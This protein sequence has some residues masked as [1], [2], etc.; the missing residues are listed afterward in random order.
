LAGGTSVADRTDR[1]TYVFDDD[2][3]FAVRVALATYRPL[4]VFGPPGVGKSSLARD[5]SRILGWRFY[6]EVVTSRTEA[7]DL[8]WHTD[9]VHRLA[10]SQVKDGLGD[11]LEYVVPGVL[12]WAFH[13][14]SAKEVARA[15]RVRGRHD[16]DQA[17]V[18]AVVLI[19]E[20]D[21]ADPDIPNN[22]LVPLGSLSF[23]GPREDVTA[24]RDEAPLV[25]ITSNNERD[26]PPAFVRRCVILNLPAP[27]K[28]HLER[29]A[30]AH[31]GALPEGSSTLYAD[32]A[33]MVLEVA[34]RAKERKP[35]TA[36]YLDFV[37]AC[38]DLDIR[39]GTARWDDLASAV[40][41][42]RPDPE[43]RSGGTAPA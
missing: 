37:R 15:A 14:A 22:L 9:L 6:S 1:R 12:W 18:R 33:E 4:L 3:V 41:E 31:F 25:F 38:L 39:R 13:P 19:D 26:L 2:I 17:G 34:G 5:V 24:A 16:P 30:R 29:V 7:Q 21:K 10:D 32:A 36:E 43:G 20:I 40:L 28:E 42:K 35:G 27:E 8:L 23:S 11:P